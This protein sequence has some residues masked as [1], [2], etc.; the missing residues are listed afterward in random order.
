MTGKAPSPA[1]PRAQWTDAE[2][3]E[4]LHD[5]LLAANRGERLPAGIR[6]A[7]LDEAERLTAGEPAAAKLPRAATAVRI[8]RRWYRPALIAAVVALLVAG[9]LIMPTLIWGR[10]S[11]NTAVAAELN[12]A[13][14][15]ADR[16][17][18][19]GGD[20]PAAGEYRYIEIDGVFV[21]FGDLVYQQEQRQQIWQPAN[22]HDVWMERRSTTGRRT[23]I[24]GS[25]KDAVAAGMGRDGIAHAEPDMR[26]ACANYFTDVCTSEGSW[27][28]PTESWMAGLPTNSTDLYDRLFADSKGHGQSQE[29]EMLVQATDALRTGL[30]TAS[31]R[32]TLYRAMAMI[33][34]VEISNTA[35]T[36]DGRVGTG[37]TVSSPYLRDETI[38][39]PTS[40]AF[41]GTRSTAI[42]E[43]TVN[44]VPAGTL[45]SS[46]A[47]HTMIVKSLGATTS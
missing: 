44:K 13:A 26:G 11:V 5:L 28:G 4:A 17:A 18:A 20:G 40:G 19:A 21:S 22:W 24:V 42:T 45:I 47:V 31:E 30:L 12:R 15:A 35:A 27:Q 33:G 37:F 46:V 2:L 39:D 1:A 38:I 14:D 23:W 25:E 32:A 3:D 29:N 7:L 6:T 9:G 10:R 36:V 8:R 43:D 41:I 16:V 34:G